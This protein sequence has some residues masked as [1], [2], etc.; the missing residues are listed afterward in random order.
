M[1]PTAFQSH[2]ALAALAREIASIPSANTVVYAPTAELWQCAGVFIT[3]D[4]Q[5]LHVSEAA[6]RGDIGVSTR[7][8]RPLSWLLFALRGDIRLCGG[9]GEQVAFF[10]R[11]ADAANCYLA[12]HQPEGA[13]WR[14]LLESV[15]SE[16]AT[17]VHER[18][19]KMASIAQ[20]WTRR[21]VRA[22]RKRELAA[23]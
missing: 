23:A 19:Q 15:L 2:P 16:A 12:A 10:G 21:P 20:V 17:I 3:S 14:P 1:N 18:R 4:T 22:Y 5:A 8:A 11:L 7:H 13:D 6:L 9:P